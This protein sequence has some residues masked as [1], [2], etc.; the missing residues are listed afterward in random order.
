MNSFYFNN[1]KDA[2]DAV[3]DKGFKRYLFIFS[4]HLFNL[5]SL[6]L[7]FLLSCIPFITIPAALIAL[8]K[9]I[10]IIYHTGTCSIYRDYWLEFKKS[11]FQ[12]IIPVFLLMFFPISVVA[13]FFIFGYSNFGIG[14]GIILVPFSYL[15]L[16]SFIF[17]TAANE[18]TITKNLKKSLL[19]IF[20]NLK[21]SLKLILVPIMLYFLNFYYL[22]Y[23]LIP[24]IFILFSA[25]QLFA[26]YLLEENIKPLSS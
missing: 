23:T 21:T 24:T 25:G 5:I 15:V 26:C 18:H 3:P 12:R 16:T 11:F 19:M 8:T 6:N 22:P 1:K 20:G 9:V 17:L 7:I 14:V 13:W 2:I 10:M 4:N